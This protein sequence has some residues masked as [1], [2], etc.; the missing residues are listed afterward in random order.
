MR[1]YSV[2][3]LMSFLFS[4]MLPAP[5]YAKIPDLWMVPTRTP[6]YL[7]REDAYRQLMEFFA[8]HKHG[9]FT[10]TGISGVGKSELA[11]DFV[12]RMYQEYDIVWWFD[13][14]RELL[15]QFQML[16]VNW[17]A[18]FPDAKDQIPLNNLAV[19]GIVHAMTSLLRKTNKSW[20]LIFDGADSVNALT[21]YLPTVHAG[22]TQ[23][24]QVLIT[25]E[26]VHDW[27]NQR[28]LKEFSEEEAIK[29][30]KLELKDESPENIKAVVNVVDHLPFRLKQAIGEI[31][32][33][34]MSI[35]GYIRKQEA[36]AKGNKMIKEGSDQFNADYREKIDGIRKSSPAAYSLLVLLSLKRGFALPKPIL[37]KFLAIRHADSD[38]AS[39]YQAFGERSFMKELRAKNNSVE[40]YSV[41]DI[42]Q[43]T[44]YEQI[45][46]EVAR[47]FNNELAGI[48]VSL[49]DTQWEDL[50]NFTSDN[51]ETIALA[52]VVWDLGLEEGAATAEL[53]RLGLSLM[54][55]HM[56]KTRDHNAYERTFYQLKDMM[57]KIGQKNIQKDILSKFY[58]N[59]VYVRGI[60]HDEKLSS[61]VKERLLA[62]DYLKD[63]ADVD[64]YLRALYNTAQ[65]YLFCADLGAAK[66]YLKTAEPMLLKAKSIS[67][68]NL[69]WYIRSWVY[70]EAGDYD[71]CNRALD[72]FFE[73]YDQEKN[74]A[75][76]LYVI[77][78]KANACLST[79]KMEEALQWCEKSLKGAQEYFQNETTEL[80]A[81]ALMIQARAHLALHNPKAARA[82]LEKSLPIYEAYFGGPDRHSDQAIA[83]RL[84]GETYLD[85]GDFDNALFSCMQAMGIY[86]ALYGE[87]FKGMNEV[88]RLLVLIATVGVKLK[89]E[90]IVQIHL[91]LQAK[92]FGVKHPGTIAIFNVI[93]TQEV[94]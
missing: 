54:E 76:K 11:I 56:F 49:L 37:E 82:S 64:L 60:Y 17:N 58:I 69:Y 79:R 41:H 22:D 3:I 21:A 57:K 14:K 24:K 33:K 15:P 36:K 89:R 20:I 53:F 10:I 93:D 7:D 94:A 48:L 29:Y 91:R 31:V 27:V 63:S 1:K 4:A 92:N 50:V 46:D 62:S 81:E 30:V 47:E 78:M 44:V 88:S 74:N 70:L 75:I 84:M 26:N 86:T 35:E 12:N 66:H 32:N 83:L 59:S 39:V 2:V 25:S 5:S 80:T 73:N 9:Q 42:V 38:F 55:Y 45:S 87:E 61:D 68:K 85:E 8:A 23:K 71:E 19:N 28:P 52:Q 72:I 13:A 51:P 40:L 77:N 90:D 43:K 67:N 16:A 65:Y 34:R 6:H 18:T